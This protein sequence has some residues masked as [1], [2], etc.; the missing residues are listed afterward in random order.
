M[1]T[2]NAWEAAWQQVGRWFPTVRAPGDAPLD[3]VRFVVVDTETSG[4]DPRRDRLLSIGACAVQGGRID[5]ATTFY[6]EL[7]QE[8]ASDADNILIHGIGRE[9]QLSGDERAEALRAFL[10]FA[11]GDPL[12]GYTTG[13]DDA[14][15][16]RAV[17]ADL[18]ETFRPE[19]FDLA[20]LPACLFPDAARRCR[21]L[22]DWLAHFGIGAIERHHALGD[23]YA[24][25]QLLLIMLARARAEGYRDL[26]GL[27]RAM[28]AGRFAER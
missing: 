17:R 11:Q 13:F 16:A 18:G 21:T 2:G 20:K 15:L 4:L 23:A 7:R 5:L 19:W 12:A 22:D 10:A 24:T 9:A 3:E 25:A 14:V 26:A 1:K 6:R 8:E 28:R 27:R